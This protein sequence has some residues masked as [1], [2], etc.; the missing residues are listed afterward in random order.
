MPTVPIQTV[1]VG[2]RDQD[3][4]EI[5]PRSILAP[6]MPALDLE[7][8]GRAVPGSPAWWIP[9]LI[10]R[11]DARAPAMLAWDAYYRGDQPLAFASSKFREA[12]GGRFKAFSSNF[13]AL[14]VDGT[15]ERM[16]IIGFTFPSKRATQRAWK[17]WQDNDMDGQSQIAHT[18]ALIKGI[19]YALVEPSILGASPRITIEDGLDAI[20]ESDPRDRR[21]RRAGLKR[22]KDDEGHLIVF[23]YTPGFVWKLRSAAPWIS[24]NTGK[25]PLEP[26]PED[27]EQWPLRNVLGVVP[28]IPLPN[29]PRL[30]PPDA[31]QSEIDP[32]MS[33]QD[34][35]NKYRADALVAAEFAAFR[36]R[37]VTGL[38][39]PEDPETG[40]PI[41]PFK[42]AVDRLWVV[43]PP[44]PEDPNPP[45][46]QFGEFE[47]TDLAPY[48]SMIESEVGAMSSISRMPYHYLLGQPQSVPPSGESLKS[49]E[50]GLVKKVETAMIHFG[51]GW[52]ETVR[53]ALLALGEGTARD[54][55][56][57][58]EWADPETKNE[59]VRADASVK[60]FSA[61][62][63]SREEA[64][65]A[66]GY[67]PGSGDVQPE[68]AGQ[69]PVIE[70][71]AGEPATV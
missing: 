6:I 57:R 22:W 62:I 51:E 20:T 11:M 67:A 59:G 26:F 38:D 42:A 52:E 36:Q 25:I 24:G 58:T 69:T 12:F 16:E 30:K 17:V 29:R 31:G 55:M 68:A 71:G 50:A 23:L 34:A 39:I 32:V 63:I 40:K 44:D 53:L 8:L 7:A 37:W 64:R 43:P 4:P 60:L 27:G 3:L 65:T 41:E 56:A 46:T 66:N 48:Q 14:V 1:Q 45:T 28:L 49:S 9:R 47:A 35:I 2:P 70:G 54:R 18:E 5:T 10:R 15:R 13:C 61:G 19:A 21:I 33:N